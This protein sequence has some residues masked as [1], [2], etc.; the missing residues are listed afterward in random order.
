M[1]LGSLQPPLGL[2][3]YTWGVLE[4]GWIFQIVTNQGKEARHLYYCIYQ[5]LD[6]SMNFQGIWTW[7][8]LEKDSVEVVS[9]QQSQQLEKQELQG[10]RGRDVEGLGNTPQHPPQ[11]IPHFVQAHLLQINKIWSNSPTLSFF[12][13]GKLKRSVKH[14]LAPPTGAGLKAL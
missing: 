11:F 5:L 10:Q 4:L 8:C 9:L 13:W 1:L 3:L 7:V 6:V 2:Q 12:S 14:S